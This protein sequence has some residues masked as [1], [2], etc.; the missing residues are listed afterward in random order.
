M[1]A[2]ERVH[3]YADLEPEADAG[4]NPNLPNDWPSKGIVQAQ[5]ASFK[6]HDSLPCVLKRVNF[7]V[8]PN[9]KVCCVIYLLYLFIYFYF[10]Q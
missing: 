6:Y 4:E 8:Q 7:T 2:V 3:E 1:V 10:F 5:N 9:E